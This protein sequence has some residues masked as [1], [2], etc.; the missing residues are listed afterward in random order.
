MKKRFVYFSLLVSAFY[1]VNPLFVHGQQTIKPS[2]PYE[3][4]RQAKFFFDSNNFTAAQEEFRYYLKLLQAERELLIS[5]RTTVEYYIAMCSI[6]SM[7]PEAEIQA[8]KFIADHPESPYTAKLITEIGVFYYETGDWVRAIKYLSNSS[9]T[10]LEHKYYLAVSYYKTSQYDQALSLFNLL[11]LE[12][13]EE[14]SLPAAYYAGV[15]HFHS[16]KFEEAIEDFKIASSSPKYTA[17][18]QVWISSAYVK[19][20]RYNDL[21]NYV[22]PILRDS[23]NRLPAGNLAAIIADLQFQK[24]DFSNAAKSY[25]VLS[26]KSPNLMSKESLYRYAFSLYKL[27]RFEDALVLLAKPSTKSLDSLDQEIAKTRALILIDQQKWDLAYT[28][29]KEVA[30]MPFNKDLAD[31]AYVLYLNL[32]KSNQQWPALLKEIKSYQK[33]APQN[34]LGDILVALAID[35]LQKQ[36]A[37]SDIEDYM[38]NFPIGKVKFQELYQSTCYHLGSNAYD[39]KDDKKAITYFKKSLDFPINREMGWYARFGLAEI[40]AKSNKNS[41]AIKIYLSLLEETSLTAGS[42][43]LSQR[44]RLSLAYSFAFITMYDR[45]LQYFEEYVANKLDGKR[46][47]DDLTNLAEIS[48]AN[49]NLQAGLKYFDEAIQQNT[50]QTPSLISRKAIILYNFRMFKEAADVYQEFINK[51]PND[52]NVDLMFYRLNEALVRLQKTEV[53]A[54]IIKNTT[55]FI[56]QKSVTNPFYAPVLLIRA[57]AYDNTNQWYLA[58]DDYVSIVR[59]F[60]ADSSAKEAIIG[61]SDLLKKAGR[62]S[63][64]IELRRLYANQNGEDPSLS[65]QWFEICSE[66]FRLGKYKLVVPELV[67]FLQEYPTYAQLEELNFML[68]VSTYHTKDFTNALNYLKQS[69]Q[70]PNFSK[71]A[72]FFTALIFEEQKQTDLAIGQLVDLKANI[73]YQDTLM[74]SV[75]DKL[76]LLYGKERKFENLTQLFADVDG[77]DSLRKSKWAVEIGQFAQ[78][79]HNYDMADMWFGKAILLNQDEVGALAA[80]GLA[81]SKAMQKDYKKSNEW[82]VSEFVKQGSSYYHLPDAIVGLAYLQMADN[83]IHLKNVPQA[84]AI[85][86]SLLSSSTDNDVKVLAKKKIEEIQ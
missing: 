3:H 51:Y 13:E 43:E 48:I 17:E 68:G 63:E 19:L 49:G 78:E 67:R 25:S 47:T 23:S 86:Q 26:D 44:I 35:A 65:D 28:A 59:K 73:S 79:A 62:H 18:A 84:K 46:N 14:F 70:S 83:F 56:Q 40:F 2:D 76:K 55:Q 37:L 74:V 36:G 21:I 34:K 10:N 4:F 82:L 5:E 20:N 22:E 24:H 80:L 39:K 75:Q 16:A 15:M 52:S 11:K 81:K 50:L 77:S 6:Y 30:N 72:Q 85:L 33:R 29:L 12:S 38:L 71:K 61:A 8:V 45:S 42:K 64:V 53:Y 69:Q 9:Q 41:D 32:L 66:M 54:Q 31:E 57:Q 60:T 7:R 27:K 1:L 58:M